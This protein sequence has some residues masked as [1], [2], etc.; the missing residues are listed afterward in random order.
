MGGSFKSLKKSQQRQINSVHKIPPLMQ[1][2]K[3]KRDI[4][5]SEE[6]ARAVKQPQRSLGYHAYDRRIQP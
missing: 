1:R 4:L 5:F 6:D 3:T 2:R